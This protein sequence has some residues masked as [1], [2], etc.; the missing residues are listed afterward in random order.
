MTNGGSDVV[1]SLL[2]GVRGAITLVAVEVLA[3]RAVYNGTSLLTE[4]AETA[5]HI[6]GLVNP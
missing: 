2:H 5:E 1:L 4:G 3:L 6:G